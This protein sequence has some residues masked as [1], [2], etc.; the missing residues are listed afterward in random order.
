MQRLPRR[1]TKQRLV[2][3]LV[4]ALVVALASGCVI[5]VSPVFDTRDALG[6]FVS[7]T[8]YPAG[9]YDDEAMQPAIDLSY[10]EM[11]TTEAVLN[12]YVLSSSAT[13]EDP[14]RTDPATS[15]VDF[16]S[17]PD[18]WRELPSEVVMVLD[19]VSRLGVDP[20]FHPGLLEVTAVYD[21]EGDGRVPTPAMLSFLT[22]AAKSFEIRTVPSGIEAR[23]DWSAMQ[24][25]AEMNRW[26]GVY[27]LRR[28]GLDVGGAAK[29]L[30]LD[31]AARSL[32]GATEISAALVTA[33][34]TT[35]TIG[36]KP[37]EEPWRI[38]VEH[39]RDPEAIM[40]SV[41]ARGPVTIST[42]GDYQR[43]FEAGGIRYHHILDPTTGKPV[44]GM[45]SL[46]VVGAETALDS[47]ILSTALF[48]MGASDAQA[49][50]EAN[51]LGLLIVDA[52]G[53]VHVVPGPE[54]RTWEIVVEE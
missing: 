36:E 8:A 34:S 39:P 24:A 13:L 23:F 46:T 17:S 38:G 26:E 3:T 6:T 30:A 29:G 10:E 50:A 1:T 43:Y 27:D 54:D 21:F 19:R 42:S 49:Y 22:R 14:R 16:N 12:A 5:A 37:D 52:E 53:R 15:V 28:A 2:A 20:Y 33:G 35:I 25:P 41:E 18:V 32:S 9:N 31:R 40:A 4:L 7:I 48:V 47:D 51:G 44:R 11:A 45:R